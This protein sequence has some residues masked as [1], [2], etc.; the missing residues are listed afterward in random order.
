MKE[1]I[2]IISGLGADKRVF[3]YIKFSA[4]DPIFIDWI[5]PEE[6]E[7]IEHYSKRISE[8]ITS[9]NPVILGISFGG[10]IAIEISK[11]IKTKKLILLATAKKRNE[12]PKLYLALGKLNVIKIVPT[13]FLKQTNFLIHYFFGVKSKEDRRLLNEIIKDIDPVF[14]KWALNKILNWTNDILPFSF[15]HIHGTNDKL[16]PV[17]KNM[18]DIE[19][20]NGGHLMTL[21]KYDELNIIINR[22]LEKIKIDS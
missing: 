12:L 18:C 16:I 22:E 20:L 11:Q 15:I 8:Q 19:I 9:E 21:N 2:Y 5:L 10:I 1:K 7:T 17:K 4:F 13:I 14:L 6:E 3:K